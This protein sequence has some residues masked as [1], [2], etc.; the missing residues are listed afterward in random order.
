MRAQGVA[1]W[2]QTSYGNP[3]YVGGGDV[4]LGGGMPT[5]NAALAAWDRWVAALA[6]RYRDKVKVWEVWNESDL[7]D[8]NPPDAYA[9][10]YVRTAEI[11]RAA[12]PE[13]SVRQAGDKLILTGVPLYDSPVLITDPAYLPYRR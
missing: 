1:P 9:A 3:I 7:N 12:I 8:D 11:I 10:L 6:V 4:Y 5:S 2:L 13:D